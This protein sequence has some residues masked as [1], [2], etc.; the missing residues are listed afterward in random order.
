[1]DSRQR[2]ITFGAAGAVLG[3][4]VGVGVGLVLFGG[5]DSAAS[6]DSLAPLVSTSVSTTV[7]TTTDTTAV[8]PTST[9]APL[10]VGPSDS[11]AVVADAPTTTITPTLD[12]SPCVEYVETSRFPL[13][14]C[15]SGPLVLEMQMNLEAAG[16]DV[17]ADGFFGA[18]TQTAVADYQTKNGQPVTGIVDQELFDELAGIFIDY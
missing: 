11:T 10:A 5:D 1:M 17:D 4:L 6:T 8:A 15:D 18:G 16:F 2:T 12:T 3:L 13:R 14:K 7:P 9:D